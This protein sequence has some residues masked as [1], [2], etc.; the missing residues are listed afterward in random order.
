VPA[1]L[2][3]FQGSAGGDHVDRV[4]TVLGCSR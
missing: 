3:W 1:H 4:F 2:E